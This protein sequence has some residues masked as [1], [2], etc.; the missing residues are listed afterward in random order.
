M[1]A[2]P[3]VPPRPIALRASPAHARRVARVWPRPSEGLVVSR[4]LSTPEHEEAAGAP[5][6]S[7]L[8]EANGFEVG[9]VYLQGHEFSTMLKRPRLGGVH[10]LRPNTA[11]ARFGQDSDGDFCRDG[12]AEHARLAVGALQLHGD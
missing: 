9:G 8:V 2:S 5:A 6:V 7:I 3:A 12:F 1:H 4:G 11:A 10:Q